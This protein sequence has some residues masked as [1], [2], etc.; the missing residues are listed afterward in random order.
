MGVPL[1]VPG[2]RGGHVQ[3]D[4]T[5]GRAVGPDLA[6]AA[7][8]VRQALADSTGPEPRAA[9]CALVPDLED[10]AR[11][12]SGRA[13]RNRSGTGHNRKKRNLT[14]SGPPGRHRPALASEP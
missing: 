5:G 14:A 12:A 7:G 2:V 4:G 13:P 10:G 11:R 1:G 6:G 9:V 8:T 3:G